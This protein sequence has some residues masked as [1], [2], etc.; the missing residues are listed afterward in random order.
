[1]ART[2]KIAAL[3]LAVRE[4]LNER[5]RDGE[6]G[7][8]ILPWLNE[9]SA[10]AL[11]D[12]PRWKGDTVINDN[13]LS[14]WRNGGYLEW[15]KGLEKLDFIEKK[16]D[17]VLRIA[18]LGN[19]TETAAQTMAVELLDL[20]ENTG[21]TV[22]GGA[23]DGAEQPEGPDKIGVAIAAAKLLD[24]SAKSTVANTAKERL[25]FDKSKRPGEEKKIAAMLSKLNLE[26]QKFAGKFVDWYE[27]QRAK[28]IM[29]N[30]GSSRAEK[31]QQLAL[32]FGEMPEGIGPANL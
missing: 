6:S 25:A 26:W 18:R 4:Q 30:A 19:V 2:G 5:L 16:I 15:C 14:N 13:A 7:A 8:Q 20:M 28:S 10:P 22:V 3:P 9:L 1:M 23:E 21:G 31:I 17:F 27:D 29:E 12:H 24:A 11:A 32:H